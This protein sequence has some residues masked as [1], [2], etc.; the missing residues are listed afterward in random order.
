MEIFFALFVGLIVALA[1]YK[2]QQADRD[3]RLTSEFVA[4][5]LKETYLP[6]VQMSQHQMNMYLGM[7][8]WH[9]YSSRQYR[10][11]T[12]DWE[13]DY[14]KTWQ[15]KEASNCVNCGAGR[16]KPDNKAFV[17]AIEGEIQ[18]S[19]RDYTRLTMYNASGGRY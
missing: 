16:R 12:T 2:V 11:A 9:P 10:P 7:Q 19:K 15:K 17:K 8:N 3:T 14:C 6:A 5:T 1:T 18:M 4:T 13:C